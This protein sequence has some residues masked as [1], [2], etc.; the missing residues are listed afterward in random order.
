M[1]AVPC[2]AAAAD[3]DKVEVDYRALLEQAD[4]KYCIGLFIQHAHAQH[5]TVQ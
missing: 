4:D 2:P 1:T 3:H 5:E